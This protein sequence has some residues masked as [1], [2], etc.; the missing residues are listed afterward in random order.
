MYVCICP[1]ASHWVPCMCV[2]VS[3]VRVDVQ[4]CTSSW[5]C[6][7]FARFARLHL[8]RLKELYLDS[9][10]LYGVPQLK[11]LGMNTVDESPSL[12]STQDGRLSRGSAF[13]P[14]VETRGESSGGGG[15]ATGAEGG[16]R[17]ASGE[18]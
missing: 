1:A 5:H 14:V 6:V 2:H 13:T 10:E 3:L 9:N 15:G 17:E 18:Y 8:R 12:P 11:L 16:R 7:C 4:S